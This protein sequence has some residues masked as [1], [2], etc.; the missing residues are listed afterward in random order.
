MYLVYQQIS[1]MAILSVRN[2]MYHDKSY[3]KSRLLA[4]KNQPSWLKLFD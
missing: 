4:P 2:T 3:R 1:V